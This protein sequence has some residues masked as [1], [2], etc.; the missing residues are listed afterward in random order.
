M[1]ELWRTGTLMNIDDLKYEAQCA[2]S[3]I[4]ID[5]ES[6]ENPSYRR[7]FL[8]TL[9]R[10]REFVPELESMYNRLTNGKSVA[11]ND[12]TPLDYKEL[13]KYTDLVGEEL[14]AAYVLLEVYHKFEMVEAVINADQNNP[15]DKSE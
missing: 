9:T 15:L 4:E 1:L 10:V 7:D 2:A 6:L 13:E 11:T 12:E 8:G 3:E 5:W 14:L